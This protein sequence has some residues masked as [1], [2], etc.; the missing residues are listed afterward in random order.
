M[1]NKKLGKVEINPSALSVIANIAATEVEGVSKLLGKKVYSRGVEL[2]FVDNAKSKLE[3]Y[4]IA[5][6]SINE[7]K[8]NFVVAVDKAITDKYN[9]G[10]LVNVLATV[11]DGRGGGRPD[12][13][14]AGAKNK[15]NINKAFEE[16]LSNI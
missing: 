4:V 9:A 11:C 14:Q 12:M 5:F 15:D 3:N 6:A 13:A 8:V 2:E 1:E 16:L 10:K 7:D